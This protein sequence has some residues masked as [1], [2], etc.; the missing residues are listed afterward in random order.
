MEGL[1]TDGPDLMPAFQAALAAVGT[2]PW[3]LGPRQVVSLSHKCLVRAG[4]HWL[5]RARNPTL[6]MVV[7]AQWCL[8]CRLIGASELAASGYARDNFIVHPKKLQT[9]GTA[10]AVARVF[11]VASGL[12]FC[13]QLTLP[14]GRVVLSITVPHPASWSPRPVSAS[15]LPHPAGRGEG[16][17]CRCRATALSRAG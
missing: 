10:P 5:I 13:A 8:G 1:R 9:A 3:Q 16:R 7:G 14:D 17:R 15:R 12:Q 4:A 6:V 2:Q 11:S